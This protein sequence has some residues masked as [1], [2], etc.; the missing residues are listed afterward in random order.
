MSGFTQV[1]KRLNRVTQF[2]AE[3]NLQQNF[4]QQKLF[5]KKGFCWQGVKLYQVALVVLLVK[6]FTKIHIG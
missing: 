2:F 1:A 5:G 4:E 3:L 6:I